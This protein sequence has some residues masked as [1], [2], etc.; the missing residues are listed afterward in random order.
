MLATQIDIFPTTLANT[1]WLTLRQLNTYARLFS[2]K[3][4][5]SASLSILIEESLDGGTTWTTV[6]GGSFTLSAGDIVSKSV[7]SNGL[8]RISG[9]G[10]TNSKGI[11]IGC[12][13]IFLDSTYVWQSP[14]L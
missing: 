12:A 7:T 4:L 11:L 13:Q 1:V 5:C 6:T 14:V 10:E 3:S 8:V 2:F 9:S